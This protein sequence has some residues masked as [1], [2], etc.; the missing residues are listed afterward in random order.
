MGD[1]DDF[2]I[3]NAVEDS[4]H[5]T[6]PRSGRHSKFSSRH[7]EDEEALAGR[8]N[9]E[10]G[11][12]AFSR[13]N[14]GQMIEKKKGFRM[15]QMQEHICFPLFF[16][17]LLVWALSGWVIHLFIHESLWSVT[18]WF[19]TVCV[20]VVCAYQHPNAIPKKPSYTG[21][22]FTCRMYRNRLLSLSGNC[23]ILLP[24][25]YLMEA[26]SLKSFF[27]DDIEIAIIYSLLLLTPWVLYLY[28]L[29]YSSRTIMLLHIADS[30][31]LRHNPQDRKLRQEERKLDKEI[32]AA[33]GT[34]KEQLEQRRMTC[35]GN[36]YWLYA[37]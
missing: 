15:S 17:T 5:G 8:A 18:L 3:F 34:R 16:L 4:W 21:K 1:M 36:R 6:F 30:M 37:E 26:P 13:Q 28:R 20:Q 31:Q 14:I 9:G 7:E 11:R 29:R 33:E 25:R 22:D 32:E 2:L 19:L 12:F 23:S 27:F 24:V 35:I 10:A